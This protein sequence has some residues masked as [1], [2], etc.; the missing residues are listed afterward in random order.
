MLKPTPEERLDIVDFDAAVTA[1]AGASAP[2][3]TDG[4]FQVW[5]GVAG[6]PGGFHRESNRPFREA[7][8]I[9]GDE[10]AVR[11]ES[12]LPFETFR[13]AGFGHVLRGR[14]HVLTIE[15]G[16]SLRAYNSFGLPATA[17]TWQLWQEKS[18]YGRKY[19]G[20]ARTTYLIGPDGKRL[21]KRHGESRIAQ[22][23]R[24]GVSSANVVSMLARWSG[25]PPRDRPADLLPH[26]G[27]ERVS[28]ARVTLDSLPPLGSA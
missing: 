8:S 17:R 14:E 1:L 12:W 28:K 6:E 27:W 16:A 22:L 7:F 25:L 5:A 23:R 4:L 24:S 11:M 18:R 2:R 13:R 9:L 15:R 19:M 10:F 21:A 3:R 26:W 20:I